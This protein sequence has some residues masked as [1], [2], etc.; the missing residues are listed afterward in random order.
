VANGREKGL[1]RFP[2]A[3]AVAEAR[4]THQTF[5]GGELWALGSGAARRVYG[6]VLTQWKAAGGAAGSYGY[7][8]TDTTASG[9]GLTC[10]FEGG[11]ITT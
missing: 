10:T 9:D 4:G 2:T 8:L 5:Q 3:A 1:L 11:T 6:A 7:P